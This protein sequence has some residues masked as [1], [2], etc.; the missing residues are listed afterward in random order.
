MKL[1]PRRS[2]PVYHKLL[3][4]NKIMLLIT[5]LLLLLGAGLLCAQYWV[6]RDVAGRLSV[7]LDHVGA[8]SESLAVLQSIRDD[9]PEGRTLVGAR[10]AF[11]DVRN[12]LNAEFARQGRR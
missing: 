1:K 3:L 5:V 6:V 12:P 8:K 2:F 11:W 10:L 9:D 4:E 7:K